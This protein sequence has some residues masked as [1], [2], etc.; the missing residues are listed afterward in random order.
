MQYSKMI[1]ILGLFVLCELFSCNHGGKL[2]K[3]EIN[4]PAYIHQLNNA[5]SETVLFDGFSPP[6]SSRIFAYVNIAAYEAAIAAD[7][8][9]ISFESQLNDLSLL[10]KLT[11]TVNYIPEVAVVRAFCRSATYFTYRDFIMDS[12][13]KTLL[14][15]LSLYYDKNELAVSIAYGD[16]I[17]AGIVAWATKD[18]YAETRKKPFYVLQKEPWSWELTP[19]QF[20]EA[21]EP[22]W[23]MIRPFVMDSSSQFRATGPPVFSTD[24]NSSFYKEAYHVYE[25]KGKVMNNSIDVANFWDCNPFVLKR[26]GHLAYFK[27]QISPGAHWIGITQTAC[28]LRKTGLKESCEVYSRTAIALADAFIACWETKYTYS[29]IRPVTYINRHIDAKWKPILE[30]P[31]F[32]EYVSGHSVISTAAAVVLEDYFGNNFTYTDSVEVPFGK[33]PRTFKSFMQAADEAAISRLFGGIH[34]TFSINDGQKQGKQIGWLVVNRITTSN[35]K[36][37]TN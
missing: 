31:P 24:K 7:K 18:R 8:K 16:S 35:K 32:P 22:Y 6:V 21:I 2:K 36:N 34:Y 37:R 27:R 28:K 23:G 10:P 29:L 17:A 5:L 20:M 30:T 1:L 33:A 13:E 9:F 19:P 15:T 11:D 26:E 3:A 14:D 25:T 12:I 4:N